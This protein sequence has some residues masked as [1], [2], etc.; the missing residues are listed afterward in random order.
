M[1][2]N[3]I[4]SPVSN[5]AVMPNCEGRLDGK[6]PDKRNDATVNLSQGD[7]LLCEACEKF[8]FPQIERRSV[9]ASRKV[10][11]RGSKVKADAAA[12]SRHSSTSDETRLPGNDQTSQKVPESNP[13][14][15]NTSSSSAS[16]Q[17]VVPVSELIV[18]EL[19]S[20]VSFYRNKCN[21]E[22]L[23]RTVMSFY[24]P[25]DVSQSKKILTGKFAAQL[26]SCAFA[27]ERRNSATRASHEAEM[28]DIVNL[29][30]ILDLQGCLTNCKF[31]SLN[32]DN[33]PKFGPEELNLA[34]VV[35][36]QMRT[37]ATV[38]DMAAT[39]DQLKTMK[40]SAAVTA[41]SDATSRQVNEL[42][43]KLELFSS[44]VCAR[45]DHLNAVCS[46]SLTAASS[47]QQQVPRQSDDVDRKLNIVIF[48]VK[49][50]RDVTVWNNSVNDV[51]RFVSG[52]DVDVIDMF[53]LGRFTGNSEG[54][55]R[56][57]LVKLRQFWDKRIILNKSSTL[58]QYKQAG[59]FI[60]P[61]E[62]AE[63]RRKSLFERLQSRAV[64]EG[65]KCVVIDGVLSVNDV[66]V[67]S[68]QTGY[69][70]KVSHG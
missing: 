19:L 10:D 39:I 37:E 14:V 11:T 59:I 31:V 51:L 33:L 70:N 29:C 12:V 67:F 46:I 8:R 53:R 28:D 22:S 20:Y 57:V 6:C 47:S 69:L 55:P 68:L 43:Q 9:A 15:T 13:G 49:E 66:P 62:S 23:R 60:V 21:V 7:L 36:R 24:S 27:A 2:D 44:S 54:R 58:K 5:C 56:P 34:A 50:D 3:A 26:G 16:V 52:H 40:V 4:L 17:P 61:D 30:D 1:S 48:G 64:K 45:L 32:L 42:Q 41:D 25:S 38:S 18:D 65:K 35:D 63:V